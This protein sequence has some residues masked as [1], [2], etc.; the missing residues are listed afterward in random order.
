MIQKMTK[1]NFNK[2]IENNSINVLNSKISIKDY[3]LLEN[4]RI[5][6]TVVKDYI[7]LNS[8]LNFINFYKYGN[9]Y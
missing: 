8:I 3:H 2:I 6:P 1:I 7:I 5:E 9:Y 4:V